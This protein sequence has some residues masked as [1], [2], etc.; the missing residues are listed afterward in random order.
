MIRTP[1]E[2]VKIFGQLKSDRQNWESHWQ[3]IS[4][5]IVPRKNDVNNFKQ[6]GVKRN[7][8]IFDNTGMN[9]CEILVGFLHGM[10]INPAA[11]F[12]ELT[13][14]DM[15]L[16][17]V[18]RVRL[19]LEDSVTRM[20]FL[21]NN[22]N[23]QTEAYEYLLDLCSLNTASQ[24][25]LESPEKVVFFQTH[26][27]KQV[28]IRE[29]YR[30]QV[31]EQYLHKSDCS[32]R[33]LVEEYGLKNVPD[34]VKYAFENGK[35][36]KYETVQATY[37]V[38]QYD[39]KDKSYK[40]KPIVSQHIFLKTKELL[41]TDGFFENPWTVSRWAKSSGETYGRGPGMNA[42]P[43]VKML[44][45][46]KETSIKGAQLTIGQPVQ[47]P[48]DGY[49][50]LRVKPYGVNYYRSGSKDR[51]E[52]I[53][54]DTR[55]DYAF[56]IINDHKQTIKETFYVDQLQLPRID[57]ATKEEMVMRR[58]DNGRFLGPLLGRLDIEW[59]NPMVDR[60]F[61]ICLR[62]GMFLP[63]P[64]ELN[65]KPLVARFSSAIAKIQ[66][67][68]QVRNILEFYN[69][70]APLVQM[71]RTVMRIINTQESAKGIARMMN[72]PQK[73]LNSDDQIAAIAEQEQQLAQQAAQ[74]QQEMHQAEVANK[75]APAVETA[76]GIVNQG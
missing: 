6:P 43:E 44:N 74:Q 39:G 37:P 42:L 16:D 58:D 28:Y 57:R 31:T 68:G 70:I 73:F 76:Q 17:A 14:G 35:E 53:F 12:F 19:W 50:K 4:D 65:G 22:S 54:N 60:V 75:M 5:Y 72:Y 45:L 30:G 52:T 7:V 61:G 66:K 48:D 3:E 34:E 56:E 25:V 8:Q 29:N 21:M 9:A 15:K 51:I 24:T 10:L 41:K 36:D 38:D 26:F 1:E 47:M 27:L 32:A 67:Q 18:D 46:M 55:I 23:F 62:R 13:T 64:P 71:D 63:V 49:G 59:L 33:Q 69:T 40:G 20:H 11:E 2:V